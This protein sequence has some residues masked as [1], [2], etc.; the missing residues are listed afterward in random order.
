LICVGAAASACSTGLS[1]P[2]RDTTM[3]LQSQLF[4]Q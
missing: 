1:D 3:L 2:I 4:C